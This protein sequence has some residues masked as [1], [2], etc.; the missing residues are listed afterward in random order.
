MPAPK[1]QVKTGA[2]AVNG[3]KAVPLAKAASPP[4]TTAT[5][6]AGAPKPKVASGAGGAKA[7]KK[8]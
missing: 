8:K 6:A 3:A 4:T 7:P 2:P 1:K 5:P